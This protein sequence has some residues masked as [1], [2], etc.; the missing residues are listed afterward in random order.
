MVGVSNVSGVEKLFFYPLS[1]I[2]QGFKF[3]IGIDS[4]REEEVVDES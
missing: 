2:R 4:Q 1:Y 3:L